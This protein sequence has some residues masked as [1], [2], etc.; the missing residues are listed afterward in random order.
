M[1]NII[2]FEQKKKDYQSCQHANV[3][4]DEELSYIECAECG[5]ELNPIK[6]L[7]GLAKREK[8]IEYRL[9]SLRSQEVKIKDR[10]R[11]KCNHCG[12]MTRI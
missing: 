1:E 4:I 3:L 10:I 9:E 11:T 5:K 8:S 2:S 6:Y 7:A 12:K